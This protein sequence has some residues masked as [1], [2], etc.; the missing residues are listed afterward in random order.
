MGFKKTT[1]FPILGEKKGYHLLQC[2][3]MVP[4]IQHSRDRH[5]CMHTTA[6]PVIGSGSRE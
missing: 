3:L 6:K 1:A 5:T 4:H 2:S